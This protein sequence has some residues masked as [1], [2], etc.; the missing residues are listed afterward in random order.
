MD[1]CGFFDVVSHDVA[2]RAVSRLLERVPAEQQPDSRALSILDVYLDS[3]A[4]NM[5]GRDQAPERIQACRG[6]CFLPPLVVPMG[7]Q[8]PFGIIVRT[9]EE[10]SS[11]FGRTIDKLNDKPITV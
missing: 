5:G 2:R 1:I 6:S 11:S 10:K 9:A 7:I 3:Y 4:F 8:P